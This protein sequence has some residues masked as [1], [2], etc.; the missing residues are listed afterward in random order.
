MNIILF[1]KKELQQKLSIHDKRIWHVRKILDKQQGE[2]FDI[3]I[4]NGPKVKCWIEEMVNDQV[5]LGY[6]LDEN[7]EES[8]Y[9]VTLI[10]GHPRPQSLKK[11]FRETTAL[12]VSKILISGTDKGEKSYFQSKLWK[13][14]KY[15]KFL[16]EG[17][18]QAHS[19]LLPVVK[20]FNKLDQCL[21]NIQMPSTLIALDNI[22]P[23][24]KLTEIRIGPE[25]NPIL[26]VGSERGWSPTERKLL[27]QKGFKLYKLGDRILRT[28]TAAVAGTTILL[29]RLNI[30]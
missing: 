4:L 26:V 12:G 15:R 3:G 17:A 8:L 11:I 16:I 19:T 1:E 21:K 6:Y 24:K 13:K 9:P 7:I 10:I 25:S 29:D 28:E 20:K 5:K 23:H 30:L 2:K 18:Q 14:D 27:I 22:N